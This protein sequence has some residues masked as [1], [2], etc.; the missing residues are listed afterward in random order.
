MK[1][2]LLGGGQLARMMA[3]AG[4]PL[5]MEFAFICPAPDA[6]TAP[7]GEHICAPFDDDAAR[8]KLAGWADVVTY[9]FENVPLPLVEALDSELDLFPPPKALAVARDRFEEKS[10][11]KALG[12]ETAEFRPVNSLDDLVGAVEE[13]GLPAILK[14]RTQ[15]YDG[16]GQA[17][18]R[19]P[20]DLPGAWDSIGGVPAIVES[21]V[22]FQRELSI[23]AVRGRSG[24]IAYYPLSENHHR[25]G[26]LRL[27]LSREN[28]PL[29]GDAESKIG[30]ILE[31]LDYVGVLALELFQVGD[32][33]LANEMAPRVHNSGHWTIEGARTSQFENHLRAVTGMEL[34]S[35]ALAHPAAMVNFIGTLPPEE[36][37]RAVPG[38]S[39]NF[40]GKEERAGRKVGHVTLIRDENTTPEQ[41]NERLVELLR[42]AGESELAEW[43]TSKA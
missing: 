2:G 22:E 18:L 38:A 34:G 30:R 15:G 19:D 26:I 40:Y 14:T 27:S 10:R 6:C 24:E 35:T 13:I 36:A 42:L 39:P 43:V 7:F 12:I 17:V 20:A 11:F 8:E 32:E 21:M 28:E 31:D 3:Q 1:V 33:L 29:Q 25:E 41:F 16:K 37:L 5:G 23:I 4:A 9:E